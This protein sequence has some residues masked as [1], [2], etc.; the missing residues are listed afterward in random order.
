MSNLPEWI[1]ENRTDGAY[2][3][4][5]ENA[6]K[7]AWEALEELKNIRYESRARDTVDETDYPA[8]EAL[9]RIRELGDF[10]NDQPQ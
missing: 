4:L 3:D 5:V 7:I 6:L 1:D 10:I 9:R 2:V 8:R